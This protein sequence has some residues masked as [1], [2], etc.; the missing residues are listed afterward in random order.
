MNF[1]SSPPA[2]SG[3]GRLAASA[4]FVALLFLSGG[5]SA[6]HAQQDNSSFSSFQNTPVNSVLDTYEQIS[7]L[8]LIRDVNLN[9][10]A[11]I[12]INASGL[13]RAGV[14]RVIE[15]ALLLNGVA[16]IPVDA[17]TAKVVVATPTKNPRSEGV[18]LFANAADLPLQDEIVSYYMPLNFIS[19]EEA[20]SIFDQEAPIHAYG[21]Y[22]P[23]PSAQAI[24]LTEETS[25]L[26][27]LIALRELIDVPPAQ[28]KTEFVQLHRA[29]AEKVATLLTN[30]IEARGGTPGVAQQLINVSSRGS[31]GGLIN[32]SAQI[33]PDARSNRILIASR[34]VNMPLLRELAEE[35]DEPD[36]S[37]K[38]QNRP[39]KYVLAGDILPALEAAVAQGK[40]EL[41]EIKTPTSPNGNSNATS[42]TP[43][44]SNNTST[45]SLGN[46]GATVTS[47]TNP[48][49]APPENDAPT[50]ATIGKTRIV[51]DNRSNSI[52][53]FGTNDAVEKVFAMIDQL[54]KRPLQVLLATVIGELTVGD[55]FEFGIDI[56]QKF[57]HVNSYGVA[58][59]SI[60]GSNST[61]SAAFP[62]PGGLLTSTGFPIL[63]GLNI[64]A[65]FGNTLNAYVRAL[66]STNRFEIISRPSVATANNRLAV[67]ASGSLVPTPGTTVSGFTGSSTDLTSSSTT[68]YQQVQLELD[69]IPL[70]NAEKK[71]TLKIRQKN[72]TL[73]ANILI[74]GNEVPT[75]NTQ[76]I[77]TEIT[78][79]DRATVVIGGLISDTKTRNTSGVPFLS[80][81]PVLGYL[82]K[83]TAKA[84]SRTELII[85]VQPTVLE[86]DADELAATEVEKQRTILGKEAEETTAPITTTA[87]TQV[88]TTH[89]KDGQPAVQTIHRS[90]SVHVESAA[91]NV[92]NGALPKDAPPTPPATSP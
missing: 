68:V 70:I 35:L 9:G 33:I 56:L 89:Q 22:V 14:L 78:V 29:D 12:S 75:I 66:E 73:G 79:P 86:S 34:P 88:I 59:S 55:N 83:D 8:H 76:E 26:R 4:L 51:A 69:I 42:P 1:S 74:S 7:G 38:P 62:E 23:A 41:T 61:S 64:Y 21:S 19:P 28:M 31:S 65:A 5:R 80:D 90:T 36:D 58:T 49:S 13:D 77:N 53:V 3:F 63:S 72:D 44:N 87:T 24:I 60:N 25:V 92:T 18:H 17:H 6:L 84:K 27:H 30:L 32:G 81:I 50:L 45:S 39:L 91:P 48:L 85:M 11:N 2:R 16:I 43:S 57:Q 52:I 37:Q 54:D 20:K 10:I 46:S 71:V 82:F 40:D 47:I 67:I 15:S